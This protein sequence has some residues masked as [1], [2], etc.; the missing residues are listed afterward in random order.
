MATPE[1]CPMIEGERRRDDKRWY[2]IT[3]SID[4]LKAQHG[5]IRAAVDQNTVITNEIK[6][7]TDEIIQFFKAGKGFFTTIGYVAKFAKW[8]TAIAAAIG[9]V[10]I[11]KGDK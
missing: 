8:V 5:E 7:N 3:Q 11:A 9:V 10:W 4:L 1:D 2:E 6:T